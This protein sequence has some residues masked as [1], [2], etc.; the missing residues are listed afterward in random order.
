ANLSCTFH[1]AEGSSL[2]ARI[3]RVAQSGPADVLGNDSAALQRATAMLRPGDALEIGPGTWQMDNSLLV[4]SAVTV[5]GTHR[6]T[7]LLKSRGVESALTEDGDYGESYLVV[8]QPEKFR[9]GMGVEVLD[10]TL[11]EGWDVTISSVVGVNGHILQLS[12][13]T[14]RDYDFEKHHA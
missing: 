8:E 3:V 13:Y 7:L 12:P 2:P 10:D 11:K 5:R 1:A 14:V 4:P 9:P 6:Q